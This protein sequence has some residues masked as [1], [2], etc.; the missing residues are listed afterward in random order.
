MSIKQFTFVLSNHTNIIKMRN[1]VNSENT[2]HDFSRAYARMAPP[3][4]KAIYREVL[5]W[6]GWCRLT[7]YNK[8]NQPA[9][10]RKPEIKIIELVFA[11]YGVNA[12]D[13]SQIE[14]LK[15]KV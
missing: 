5:H 3:Q 15:E 14:S 10:L 8:K 12:W 4:R 11:G 2:V 9:R 1:Q 7:F 6:T 13:G